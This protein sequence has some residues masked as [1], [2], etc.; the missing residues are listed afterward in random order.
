MYLI[1]ITGLV[2]ITLA[3]SFLHSILFEEEILANP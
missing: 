2:A 3:T 1:L